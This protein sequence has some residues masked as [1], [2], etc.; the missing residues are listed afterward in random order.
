M[1]QRKSPIQ[2]FTFLIY[3]LPRIFPKNKNKIEERNVH[4]VAGS[5]VNPV[6]LAPIPIPKLL[7]DKDNPSRIHVLRES[8]T[9]FG[10]SGEVESGVSW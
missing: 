4:I 7:R 6:M 8:G 3:F 1:P 9:A 5:K 10:E 2:F